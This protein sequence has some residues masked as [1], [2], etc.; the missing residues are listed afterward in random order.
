MRIKRTFF[1]VRKDPGIPFYHEAV[2]PDYVNEQYDNAI[3]KFV[4]PHAHFDP[5]PN[6]NHR[7]R[8]LCIK[9]NRKPG[10]ILM[11]GLY[12]LDLQNLFL[13]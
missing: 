6:T 5:D 9:T 2:N 11:A 12:F 3:I 7:M 4:I 10:I 13:F 1:Y 8:E